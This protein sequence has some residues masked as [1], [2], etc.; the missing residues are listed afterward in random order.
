M[1]KE[2]VAFFINTFQILPRHVSVYGCHPQSYPS[3]V[4]CN[5]RVRILTRPVW[6]QLATRDGSKFN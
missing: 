1:L 2:V 6:P 3:G 4:L 5:G